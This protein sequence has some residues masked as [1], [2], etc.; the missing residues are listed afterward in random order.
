MKQ[1]LIIIII[2]AIVTFTAIIGLRLFTDEDTWLCDNGEWVKHGNP[3]APMPESGC[4]EEKPVITSFTECEQ[5]GNTILE[6]YPR[7]CQTPEEELFAEDIG[8]ELE[9][10]DFIRVDYPRPN[11]EIAS[12]LVISGEARGTW[13][14]EASFP[15]KLYYNNGTVLAAGIATTTADWMTEDFIPFQAVLTFMAPT[16]NYGKLILEK[17]N[18]SGLLEN[19]DELIIPIKF[20]QVELETVKVYFNNELLDPE[21][22]CDKVFPV[23]RIVS[24]ENPKEQ[25]I[26]ELLKGATDQEKSKGYITSIN[27]N[28][29][30][31][32]LTINN[33]IAKV[34]FDEQL[35]FEVGGSCR[36]AA[37]S[38]QIRNTL[39]QFPDINEVIISINGRTED[40]LQP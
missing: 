13:F 40:V 36:V 33:G 9:K 30:L 14:F 22:S 7:Q 6:S 29:Q 1:A 32:S 39:L 17:D 11:Q 27:P 12:P 3:S 24:P 31:Q 10:T 25:A 2:L 23:E 18:P 19:A 38:A 28:V 35:E 5:A 21:V 26:L 4:G 37:I 16:G 20:G 34:D 15:V 8:N